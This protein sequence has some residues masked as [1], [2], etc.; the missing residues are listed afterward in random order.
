MKDVN[1]GMRCHIVCVD[2]YR[3][4]GRTYSFHFQDKI[5][6]RIF[7]L[8]NKYL[9]TKLHGVISRDTIFLKLCCL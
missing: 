1:F 7:R 9:Y 8:K 4:F 3:R 2:T 6:I 5:G